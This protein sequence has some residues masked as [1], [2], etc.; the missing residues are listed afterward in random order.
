MRPHAFRRFRPTWLREK[1]VP[2]DLEDFWMGHADEEL[3]DLYSQLESNVKFRKEVAERIGLGF[4]LPVETAPVEPMKPKT[5]A[6]PVLEM[7]AS[8]F[9]RPGGLELPTSGSYQAE[10][11]I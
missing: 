2:K 4:E 10:V 1:A 6:T 11:K 9:E 5:E 8:A 3:G 7:A